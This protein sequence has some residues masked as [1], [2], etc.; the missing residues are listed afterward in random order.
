M[1]KAMFTIVYLLEEFTRGPK[2]LSYLSFSVL[3]E[4][5]FLGRNFFVGIGM[6]ELLMVHRVLLVAV[7]AVLTHLAV[8]DLARILVAQGQTLRR[9]I[10]FDRHFGNLLI[11]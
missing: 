5:T 4:L 7:L 3:F 8:V 11:L 6:S 2:N 9:F 1:R 10:H